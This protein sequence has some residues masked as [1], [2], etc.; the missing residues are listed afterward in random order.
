MHLPGRGDFPRVDDHLVQAE[1]TRDEIIG[2]RRV[3][4]SPAHPPHANQHTRLDYVLQ[5]HVAPGYQ[6]AN[7]LLTRHDHD[8]DFATD[9][10]IYKQGT[11]PETGAR[12]LEEIAF[13]VVSEQNEGLV[14]QKAVRMQRRGV[15]RIF[16]V[17]VKG[18]QRVCEWSPESQGW[19]LLDRESSIQDLCLVRPL[20]VAALLDA[21]AADNAVVEALI[22]KGN[23]V[24]QEREAAA[25]AEGKAEG[26]ADAILQVLEARGVAV[27]PSQRQEILESSGLDR[28]DR[29]LRRAAT[30]SSADEVTSEP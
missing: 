24:L 2:G 9:V 28:L 19:R 18:S 30:A 17:W 26:R 15:R 21:A 5:A 4:A 6:A 7:D 22:V 27:S 23:P 12:Y 11:D 25:R 29:W 3:V 16:S 10:C 20:S 1:V 14:T 13:E 8:S